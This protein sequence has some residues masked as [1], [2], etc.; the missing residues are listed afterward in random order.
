M[1][2]E[3]N[4]P[5]YPYIYFAPFYSADVL[6]TKEIPA[7]SNSEAMWKIMIRPHFSMR[8]LCGKIIDK[9]SVEDKER[10]F[11][12]FLILKYP[13]R[14]RKTK[15][16]DP[17]HTVYYLCCDLEGNEI[18]EF[19]LP[20]EQFAEQLRDAQIRI[21]TLKMEIAQKDKLMTDLVEKRD[22]IEEMTRRVRE[23]IAQ[24]MR[25]FIQAKERSR[26]DRP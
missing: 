16:T 15:S 4:Q 21:Q 2:E 19:G 25:V 5:N 12:D 10:R 6:M 17:S 1:P 24:E 13:L 11:G 9:I 20:D 23:T 14:L 22:I 26:D 7:T 3:P 18:H 8:H